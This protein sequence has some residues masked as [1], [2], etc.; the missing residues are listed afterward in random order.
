MPWLSSRDM[1]R[2]RKLVSELEVLVGRAEPPHDG[3]RPPGPGRA[4]GAA[5]PLTGR[6]AEVL[7]W[8]VEG[9]TNGE[10]AT[11]L[12]VR[13]RT[14]GKHCERVYQKLGVE[15]RTSAV[16]QALS[17]DGIRRRSPSLA[18]RRAAE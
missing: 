17:L 6:E 4:A 8:L 1:G 13:P 5:L 3:H 10:I 7:R 2:L 16:R 12:A 11:I 9:K 15:N 14:V 18:R